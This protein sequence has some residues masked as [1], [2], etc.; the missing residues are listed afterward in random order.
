MYVVA[1]ES[2][3]MTIDFVPNMYRSKVAEILG[4]GA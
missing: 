4:A 2:G 1:V 3:R